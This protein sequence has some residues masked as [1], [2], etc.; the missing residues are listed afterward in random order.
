MATNS[1]TPTLPPPP[2][3]QPAAFTFNIGALSLN[4]QTPPAQA[5]TAPTI[6]NVVEQPWVNTRFNEQDSDVQIKS[7]DGFIFR[8]HRT[9]LE[10]NTG[11]FPGPEV[12]TEGEESV[13]LTEKANVLAILFSFIYPKRHP[14]LDDLNFQTVAGVAE[15]AGKYEVFAAIN[16]CNARLMKFVPQ[17]PLDIFVHSVKHDYPKLMNEATPYLCRTPLTPVLKRLPLHYMIAWCFEKSQ[18]HEAWRS[19]F[20]EAA[21]YVKNLPGSANVVSGPCDTSKGICN[22]CRCALMIWVSDLEVIEDISRLNNTLNSP[23]MKY[24]SSACCGHGYVAAAK[25]P[26]KYVS[27]IANLCKEK[28][29]CIPA[30]ATYLSRKD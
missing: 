3:F 23:V 2:L 22:T 17:Y 27:D 10:M 16:T 19:V 7:A 26:C 20:T 29:R 6:L 24:Q 28:I 13:P 11:A 8:L 9:L 18:Y 14:D 5:V 4:P 21:K 30:F 25:I 12:S 1:T 15:A